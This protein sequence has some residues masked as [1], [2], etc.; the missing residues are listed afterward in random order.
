MLF[1]VTLVLAAGVRAEETFAVLE[2]GADTYANVTVVSKTPTHVTITHSKGLATLKVKELGSEQQSEL[3]YAVTVE[4]AKP[5]GAIARFT[6]DREMLKMQEQVEAQAEAF[7]KQLDSKELAG[8]GCAL[9]LAYLFF[10]YCC[11]L[12]CRKAGYE[13][14]VW[15]WIPIA[16]FFPMFKA[17]KMSGWNFLLIWLPIIGLVV[18][19]IWCFKICTAR[20]KSP[21][22]GLL[23]LLPVTNL[24]VFL[25][26]AFSNGQEAEEGGVIRLQYS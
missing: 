19:I 3:G 2:V 7:I 10:C 24:L 6:T 22:L 9:V 14:G 21:W 26:L 16:Q 4:E 12:I 1:L 8:I 17:A 15:I 20:N 13:P 11:C 18:S 23:L 5:E 25:Y